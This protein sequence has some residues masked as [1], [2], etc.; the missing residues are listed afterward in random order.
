MG[1][2]ANDTW[3]VTPKL[4][5]NYGVRW[6]P[7]IPMQFKQGDDYNF[8]LTNFY[9]NVRSTKIPTAPPGFVYP[10][11]PGFNGKAG[12]NNGL[13]HFEPRL[14]I[15]WDPFGDGKTAIRAGAGLAYDFIREDIHENTSSVLPFRATIL[16]S[17]SR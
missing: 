13:N 16:E 3:K 4:T 14:G 6:N 10:G 5:L 2:Y 8:S 15:A 17:F 1:L 12:M 11:D 7:F 9:A